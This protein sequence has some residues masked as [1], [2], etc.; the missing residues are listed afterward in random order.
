MNRE[1]YPSSS[2]LVYVGRP[3]TAAHRRINASNRGSA[4]KNLDLVSAKVLNLEVQGVKQQLPKKSQPINEDGKPA[5]TPN[6]VNQNRR[7]QSAHKSS[8][9]AQNLTSV[10]K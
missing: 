8:I 5:A 1:H 10:L 2:G 6:F 4:Q 7:L 3:Q 9:A